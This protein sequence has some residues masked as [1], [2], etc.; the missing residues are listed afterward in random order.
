MYWTKVYDGSFNIFV[1]VNIRGGI[2]MEKYYRFEL[3]RNILKAKV[4]IHVLLL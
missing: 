2:Q 3:W 4:T 1:F